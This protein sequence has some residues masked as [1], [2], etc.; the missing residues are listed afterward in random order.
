MPDISVDVFKALADPVR[1]RILEA[2]PRRN[3]CELL[4]NVSELAVDLKLPQSTVSRHLAILLKA[5]LVLKTRACREVY[6][7]LN[8]PQLDAVRRAIARLGVKPGS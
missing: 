6:Y 8:T 5:E 4:C 3:V 7:R 2:L 1:L